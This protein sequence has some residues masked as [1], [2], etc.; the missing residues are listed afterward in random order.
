MENN[1]S[2]YSR[3]YIET[4]LI[5]L[6]LLGLL[7][8]ALSVLSVFFG[9]I[10]FAIIFSVSF[11][12]QFEKLTKL[13][14]NKR[15]LA[16][17][18]Y[19]F[20]ILA[21]IAQPFLYLI[22]ALRHHI[23]D[24]STFITDVKTNGLPDLSPS[25]VQMPFIGDNIQGFWKGLQSQPK[26]TIAQHEP[27]IREFL[28]SITSGGAG[29]IGA[30]A[31]IGFG[32]IISALLLYH[33][34]EIIKVIRTALKHLIGEA[35]ADSLINSSARALKGV[36]VGIMGTAFIAAIIAWIGLMIA[37]VPFSLG[38][39]ALIFFLVIIQIGPLPVWVPLI[40]WMFIEDKTGWAIFMILYGLL[41]VAA[42]S[43]LKPMLIAKSGKLPFL[44]L[45]IGVIG[46]MIT[47]GFTG[48][49]KGAI[50]MA[51]VYTIFN[52]WLQRKELT[53]G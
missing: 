25:I 37:G 47:W 8:A 35:D 40:I 45:F 29:F 11:S 32:C 9:V 13:L 21:I 38:I 53:A 41:L 20:I 51:I 44:I 33:S 7:Y 43:V 49:F 1:T 50:I 39:A 15:K 19:A 17:F 48:M 2:T 12:N 18:L 4:I 28:H 27:Q 31:E 5:I 52:T 26:E 22:A 14:K 42:D 24:I 46:G 30:V 6:I 10:T 3:N 36:S 16:A 34:N 23:K